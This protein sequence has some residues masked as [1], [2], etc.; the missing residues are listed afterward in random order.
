[1]CLDLDLPVCY[2]FSLHATTYLFLS[3][4]FLLYFDVTEYISEFCTSL[5]L[6]EACAKMKLYVQDKEERGRHLTSV[7]RGSKKGE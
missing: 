4:P 5:V 6:Q 1:M 2:L 3:L 7:K